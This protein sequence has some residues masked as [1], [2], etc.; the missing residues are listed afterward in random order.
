VARSDQF[1]A[2][3]A[4]Q[5]LYTRDKMRRL[6]EQVW[7]TI[8]ILVCPTASITPTISQVEASH[9]RINTDL[10][11]YTNF[12]NLLDLCALAVPN[13]FYNKSG[14]PCGI[15]LMA[16]AFH[17]ALLAKVGAKF[18]KLNNLKLGATQHSA[19]VYKH[20]GP[21]EDQFS[22]VLFAKQPNTDPFFFSKIDPHREGMLGGGRDVETTP[23]AVVGAHLS[24]QPL[25]T[26]LTELDASLART[27]N[28]APKY[29]LYYLDRSAKKMISVPGL[30]K[31]TTDGV[32]IEVEVWDVPTQLVGRFMS[33]VGAPLSIG[34]IELSDGTV[35]KGF[36][37]ES[38]AIKDAPD[39]SQFGGWRNY[40][41]NANKKK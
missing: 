13:A 3:N 33:K 26:Q 9:V 41:A 22:S 18:Q 27:V 19:P 17:D 40:L 36:L 8:D 34:N 5:S 23:I 16:P 28:T 2:V 15:T 14:M 39:I 32:A 11:Y 4:F 20:Y 25:N 37:V 10:G 6:T 30:L 1:S 38:A 24:G 7:E 21:A 31:T 12:V 35:V 29:R